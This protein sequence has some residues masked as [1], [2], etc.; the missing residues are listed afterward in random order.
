MTNWLHTWSHDEF[1]NMQQHEI[2]IKQ[3][4]GL[5]H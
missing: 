2:A 4:S 5:E 3:M 1:K